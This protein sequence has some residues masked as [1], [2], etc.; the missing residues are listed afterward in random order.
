MVTIKTGWIIDN[1][2]P[3]AYSPYIDAGM[4]LMS[5]GGKLP[6]TN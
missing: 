3:A 1:V 5:I 6:E 4:G 2:C